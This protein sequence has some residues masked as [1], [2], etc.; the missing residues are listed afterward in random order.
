MLPVIVYL[1]PLITYIEKYG[2][3]GKM[4]AVYHMTRYEINDLINFLFQ[5]GGSERSDHVTAK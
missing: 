1:D 3:G 4:A 2:P 5:S